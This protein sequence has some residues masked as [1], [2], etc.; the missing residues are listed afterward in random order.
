MVAMTR[1]TDLIINNFEALSTLADYISDSDSLFSESSMSDSGPVIVS[2]NTNSFAGEIKI[3]DRFGNSL[4]NRV[5][6]GLSNDKK[7]D[8]NIKNAQ[9][10]K[11]E[12]D[13]ANATL[14]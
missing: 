8:F 13:T 3:G 6:K 14:V 4:F 11:S 12:M 10:F 7:L 9:A 5:V 1:K 2:D